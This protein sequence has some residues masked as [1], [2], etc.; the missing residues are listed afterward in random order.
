MATGSEAAD[1]S[2]LE[3]DAASYGATTAGAPGAPAPGG[4][5]ST[6][7]ATTAPAAAARPVLTPDELLKELTRNFGVYKDMLFNYFMKGPP[8]SPPLRHFHHLKGETARD[9]S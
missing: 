6:R 5:G 2:L 4:R 3:G 8:S 7:G 1:R 9:G